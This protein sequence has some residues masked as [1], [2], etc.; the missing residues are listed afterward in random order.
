[1][2]CHSGRGRWRT[3][4]I[5][6]L[7]AI[8]VLAVMA[9]VPLLGQEKM[10]ANYRAMQD[11]RCAG[12]LLAADGY[13]STSP[14]TPLEREVRWVPIS[15]IHDVLQVAG[16]RAGPGE[17]GFRLSA[18]FPGLS[19]PLVQCKVHLLRSPGVSLAFLYLCADGAAHSLKRMDVDEVLP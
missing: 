7:A 4:I 19:A 3:F 17:P 15:A 9:G 10:L 2:R 6:T 1:M 13:W 18:K 11:L 12:G 14:S 5:G 16:V 8:L